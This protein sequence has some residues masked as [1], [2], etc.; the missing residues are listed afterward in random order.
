MR[1]PELPITAG[2][3]ALLLFVPLVRAARRRD[4]SAA[5]LAAWLL[6]ASLIACVDALV[7]ANSTAPALGAWCAISKPPRRNGEREADFGRSDEDPDV[8]RRRAPRVRALRLRRPRAL[9]RAPRALRAPAPAH[10]TCQ[11][12]DAA[13]PLCRRARAV[14]AHVYVSALQRGEAQLTPAQRSAHRARRSRSSRTS[15]AARPCGPRYPRCSS[16]A[17]RRGCSRSARSCT[18]VCSALR[19]LYTR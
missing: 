17:S 14:H 15:A 3:C 16:S 11:G 12:G 13:R 4:A 6:A 5:A 8:H 19:H 2:A 7:W 18:H 9:R 10:G 1:H